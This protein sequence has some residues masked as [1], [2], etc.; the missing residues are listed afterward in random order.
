MTI[1][2][3]QEGGALYARY[4]LDPRTM[5]TATIIQ[6]HQGEW[7]AI[8]ILAQT[9]KRSKFRG[10]SRSQCVEWVTAYIDEQYSKQ[11]SGK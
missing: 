4:V 9:G 1:N 6:A 5:Y 11:E 8:I 3:R 10:E 7:Y 2:W